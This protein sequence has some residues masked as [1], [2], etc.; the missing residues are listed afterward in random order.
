MQ[1]HLFS[2]MGPCRVDDSVP[3]PGLFAWSTEDDC[4]VFIVTEQWTR[5]G[6][7][8]VDVAPLRR[9]RDIGTMTAWLRDVR[10]MPVS[11]LHDIG[12]H[13]QAN[14]LS[15]GK[16]S[17]LT[18]EQIDPLTSQSPSVEVLEYNN[19]VAG[20]FSMMPSQWIQ[21]PVA[22]DQFS[23]KR[24][25]PRALRMHMQVHGV[26]SGQPHVAKPLLSR[27]AFRTVHDL[28]L[29]IVFESTPHRCLT[30]QAASLPCDFFVNDDDVREAFPQVLIHRSQLDGQRE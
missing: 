27:T 26:F 10:T 7:P 11:D 13:F 30:C 1:E 12:A 15:P 18:F 14:Q 22:L 17:S 24:V 29:P 6:K 2:E 16:R 20:L 25:V 21:Q 8:V 4:Y 5:R 3:R 9:L 19:V 23:C 28:P